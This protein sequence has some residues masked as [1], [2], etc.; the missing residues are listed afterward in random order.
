MDA[1]NSAA[2]AIP[3]TLPDCGV[4]L[5]DDMQGVFLRMPQAGS[6]ST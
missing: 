2:S 4:G 3:G 5:T 1:F 6:F